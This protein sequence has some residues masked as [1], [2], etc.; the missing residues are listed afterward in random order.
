[1]KAT[2]ATATILISLLGAHLTAAD[3]TP[4]TLSVEQQFQQ[5]DVQLAIE[6]YKKLRM[7]AFELGLKVQTDTSRSDE[8]R[9]QPEEMRAKLEDGAER[10]RAEAVKAAAI[11][12]ANAR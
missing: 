2:L 10:I 11:A 1:M 5:A 6:Q 4:V 3:S 12:V 9:K 8:E 7:T